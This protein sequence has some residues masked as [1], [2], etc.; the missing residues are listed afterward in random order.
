[1]EAYDIKNLILG[2]A[3]PRR[4]LLLESLGF[5]FE[6]RTANIEEVYPDHLSREE[7]TDYLATQKANALIS[8]MDPTNL[9]L[10][11]DTVVWFEGRVMEKPESPDQAEN[12][13]KALSGNWHE[14]IT[15]VCFTTSDS[16]LLKHAITRVKFAT[17]KEDVI[18]SYVQSGQAMDKAGAY[19]IQEW[20]GLVGVER[21]EGSYTNVV[22][23]PTQLV[24][25]TLRDMVASKI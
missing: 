23:L 6:V 19:G 15:S 1:M 2:S 11:A 18:R 24:Y 10:T 16:Q 9:I 21:I 22:G 13:L 7:I 14:V 5:P 20:I 17:L 8:G 3:S 25:K 12:T 4:K